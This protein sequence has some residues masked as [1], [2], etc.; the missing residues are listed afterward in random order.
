M[1]LSAQRPDGLWPY[2]RGSG[3]EWVDTFH[4]AYVL[5]GLAELAAD[6]HDSDLGD[7]L[8]R[9]FE[10]YLARFFTATGLPKYTPRSVHPIDIHGA[11]TAIDVLSRR[12]VTDEN[13]IAVATRV[14][15]WTLAN[16]YDP[17]GFFYFQRHRLYT[18]KV[19]YIRW[20][21]AHMFKA[22]ATLLVSLSAS[23]RQR[24]TTGAHE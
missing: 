19:P 14:C 16:M 6:D 2:G 21:Q 23:R 1:T 11:A 15:R 24:S 4:T 10:A 22:L 17:R 5:D 3:L 12:A 8:H 18:N 13:R 9:G 7:S 20:S